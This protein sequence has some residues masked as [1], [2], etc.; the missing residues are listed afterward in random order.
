MHLSMLPYELLR[1]IA[2]NLLPRYQCRFALASSWCYKYLYSDLLKWHARKCSITLPVHNTVDNYR[3][4]TLLFTGKNVV[5]YINIICKLGARLCDKFIALN[6]STRGFKSL[7]H[8][9]D[10]VE[11]LDGAIAIIPLYNITANLLQYLNTYRRYLHK[12]VL[13]IMVNKH[14]IPYIDCIDSH[15]RD[16]IGSF[17]SEEDIYNIES[18]E[19]LS[20]LLM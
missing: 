12:D 2:G 19:Y 20:I 10:T 5:L 18:C 3:K 11:Y 7:V 16:H 9:R 6:M 8:G 4:Q 15:I 17:L 1:L 13:L 14:T